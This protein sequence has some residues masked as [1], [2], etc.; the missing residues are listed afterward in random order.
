MICNS[1][2]RHAKTMSYC[3]SGFGAE[4]TCFWIVL[5]G[6]QCIFV[7]SFGVV[8]G[9]KMLW[10]LQ[11]K[12]PAMGTKHK[13]TWVLETPMS[14][15]TNK[16]VP[17]V[18]DRQHE[19]NQI[20]VDTSQFNNFN[21]RMLLYSSNTINIMPKFGK[22]KKKMTNSRTVLIIDLMIPTWVQYVD[23]TLVQDR[24]IRFRERV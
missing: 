7:V 3:K 16:S 22:H 10:Q 5:E 4:N 9:K 13:K 8:F 23:V 21:K 20:D 15:A 12:I 14:L 1:F 6:K 19:L 18:N 17:L 24:T 2:G 11:L